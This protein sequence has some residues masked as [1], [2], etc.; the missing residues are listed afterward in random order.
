MVFPT[1][2]LTFII[3]LKGEKEILLNLILTCWVLMNVFWMLHELAGS[4]LYIAHIFMGIGGLLTAKWIY[5]H[6]PFSKLRDI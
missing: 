6:N 1:V 3:L 2:I 4:P 5:K